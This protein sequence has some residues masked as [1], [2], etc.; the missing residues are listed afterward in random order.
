MNC[1]YQ[2]EK[3]WELFDPLYTRS[4]YIVQESP[5]EPPWDASAGYSRINTNDVDFDQ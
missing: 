3:V 1:L 2:G 5:D 4:L